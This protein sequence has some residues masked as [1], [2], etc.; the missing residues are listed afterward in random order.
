MTAY[1]NPVCRLAPATRPH[2]C[3]RTILQGCKTTFD[4]IPEQL[5][6]RRL[7]QLLTSSHQHRRR[8]L[9]PESITKP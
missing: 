1:A 6:H 2:L 8:S 3:V 7:M 4:A 9:T 5:D